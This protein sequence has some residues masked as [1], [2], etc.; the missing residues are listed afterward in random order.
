MCGIAGLL[1]RTPQVTDIVKSTE[2]M[3]ETL[4]HR[5][6]DDTGIWKDTTVGIS[7][8]HRRLS[9]LDLSPE[10]HQPM[11]SADGRYIIVF[12]GEI[13]NHRQLRKELENSTYVNNSSNINWR[14]HSDT[15]VMLAAIMQWGLIEAIQRFTG[16]FAFALWDR[17][18]KKLYLVR[19]RIGE[20]PLYYGW[21]NETFLFGSELKALRAYPGWRDEI[22]REA[23]ALYMQ[24]NYVPAPNTIYKGIRKLEPGC[25]AKITGNG[26][27]HDVEIQKYW[28]M[29]DVVSQPHQKINDKTAIE[30]TESLLRASVKRQMVAD[31]PLGAFLSGGVDSSL[32]VA[33]MQNQSSRPVRTFTI[34]FNESSFNEA[35]HALAVANHL[36]T[37]HTEFY[38]SPKD[39]MDV[40]PL[41]PALYDEPFADS[42]QIPTYLV[43]RMTQEHVS[44]S[45]SGDGGDEFFGGY[46]RYSWGQ[47]IWDR[48]KLFPLPLRRAFAS[49]LRIPSPQ[50]W[51]RLFS[52][53]KYMLP[54]RYRYSSAGDKLHKLAK[55]LGTISPNDIFIELISLWEGEGVVIGSDV[56]TTAATDRSQWPDNLGFTEF[57]MYM[58]AKTYLPDDIMVKVDRAAMGV[59]LESRAPFLDHEVIEFAWSLPL[60]MKIRHGQGKWLLRQIL[61]KYVP[62]NLIERPK[63][64]FGVPIDSWLRGPLRSWAE[65]L[66]DEPYI[67]SSGYLN[68]TAIRKKWDEHLSGKRNWQHELWGVLMFQAWLKVQS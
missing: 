25:I 6:P 58:D 7:L 2:G 1:T 17:K 18:K 51:D 47:N 16:M 35:E 24:F 43:S 41:L 57:M 65:E 39:A 37:E 38:V 8:A 61:Y 52:I 10:G 12:N 56:I 23:L 13:Y 33:L 22:D 67:R 34:G 11:H 29:H 55:L 63:M 68:A 48:I 5:G 28:S 15:E 4:G 30:R 42:S 19:D 32:I 64:G 66:L 36:G 40:I 14:G 26:S 59:S 20:K 27:S 3:I 50:T 46:N 21:S 31:V 45:L 60:N 49:V 44:V 53:F 9:I 54:T 62:Q